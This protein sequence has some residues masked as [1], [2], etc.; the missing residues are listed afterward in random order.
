MDIISRLG[1]VASY[2][3][4]VQYE[5]SAVYHPQPGILSSESGALVR[6]VGDNANI[7]VQTLDGNNT[8]HVMG[9]IEIVTPKNA[10]LYDEQKQKCTTKPKAKELAAISHVS[11]QVYD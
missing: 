2:S 5:V 9:I 3:S 8:L 7:N 1:F 6:Y 4:T 10:V 11:L